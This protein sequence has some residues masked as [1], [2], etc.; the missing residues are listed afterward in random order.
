MTGLAVSPLALNALGPSHLGLSY[1]GL[2][3]VFLAVAVAVAVV[4]AAV[5]R[6]GRRWWVAT[7]VTAVVLVVLTAVFDS[8]MVAADLFRYGDGALSGAR[9]WLAPVEDLAWPLAAALLLPAVW[10]LL[11]GRRAREPEE[12][13]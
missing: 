4:A 9:L 5:R 7:V 3:G 6:L 8:V 11:G 2:A 10:E 1:L 12:R 13:P